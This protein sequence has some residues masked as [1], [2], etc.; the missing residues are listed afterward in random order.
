MRA[1][2]FRAWLYLTKEMAYED[3]FGA[4]KFGGRDCEIMQ[5][6]GLK[7]KN[8]KEIY[9]GD[10]VQQRKDYGA[11]FEVIWDEDGHWKLDPIGE[12]GF[13]GDALWRWAKVTEVIG[14]IYEHEHLLKD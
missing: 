14:N 4:E 2:K 13:G 7:D 12:N 10:V 1:I 9:E 8:G 6:T 3:L 11:R 5:F